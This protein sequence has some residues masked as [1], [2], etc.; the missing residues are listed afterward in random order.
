MI[1]HKMKLFYSIGCLLRKGIHVW[2]FTWRFFLQVIIRFFRGR[3]GRHRMTYAR[4]IPIMISLHIFLPEDKARIVNHLSRNSNYKTRIMTSSELK[5]STFKLFSQFLFIYH[6]LINHNLSIVIFWRSHGDLIEGAVSIE[7]LYIMLLRLDVRRHWRN[8]S[9]TVFHLN[10]RFYS[11]Y[12][13][14]LV[15]RW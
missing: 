1:L 10:V 8:W 4:I 9:C 3:F 2:N 6:V 12:C 5:S 13:R 7:T 15:L 14:S 11:K